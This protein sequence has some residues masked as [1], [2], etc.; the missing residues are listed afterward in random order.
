MAAKG[1]FLFGQRNRPLAGAGIAALVLGLILA[2]SFQSAPSVKRELQAS[3]AWM[4]DVSTRLVPSP[5]LQTP[6]FPDDETREATIAELRAEIRALEA[7]RE[8]AEIQRDRLT[9][10]ETVL[11]LLGEPH[12]Q[13]VTARVI[14]EAD[15]PFTD[16]FV[17]NAGRRDNVEEG[18]AAVNEDGLVG[19]VIRVGARTSRILKLTDYNSRVPVMGRASRDRALLVGDRVVGARLQH[20]ETPD[21]IIEGEEW[22]TSGDDGVL[23]RGLLVGYAVS[24][25]DGW[26]VDLVLERQP[27]DYVRLLPPPRLESPDADEEI[28]P[29]PD[30]ETDGEASAGGASQ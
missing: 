5:R 27:I 18:F 28:T 16:T 29:D 10:Y 8:T 6:L 30:G 1:N 25:D 3:R 23:P 19:R 26:S 15:S 4:D 2:L 17:A 9:E 21:A 20:A 12:A 7:W 24:T 22:V 14:A 13:E 11:D